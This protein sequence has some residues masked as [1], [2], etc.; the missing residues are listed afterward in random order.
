MEFEL[1]K[2]YM[3]RENLGLHIKNNKYFENSVIRDKLTGL[4]IVKASSWKGNLR[5]ASEKMEWDEQGKTKLMNRL[6]GQAGEKGRLSF[7]TTYFDKAEED[8]ITPL[9]RETKMPI[10]GP[11][12]LEVVP[13]GTKGKISLLYFPYPKSSIYNGNEVDED[14]RFLA[15]SLWHMFY[16]YGFSARKTSGFGVIKQMKEEDIS[17]QTKD[18][19]KTGNETISYINYERYKKLFSK[20]WETNF[21]GGVY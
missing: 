18:F 15:E 21:K 17:I 14:L 7:F 16:V 10:R 13:V 4:P 20:L 2:P 11:I 9:S 1:I 3:S 12:K 5:F 6:F 19:K 8:V